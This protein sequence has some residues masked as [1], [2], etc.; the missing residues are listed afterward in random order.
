MTGER[1]AKW[2]ALLYHI[3]GDAGAKPPASW[4]KE[5]DARLAD[6]DLEDFRNCLCA[7]FAPVRSGEPLPLSVAGSHVL[8]GLLWYCALARDAALNEAALCLVDARWK[9]KRNAEKCTTALIQLLESMPPEF[10]R[11]PMARLEQSLAGERLR[12]LN[13]GLS[14]AGDF[15]GKVL[16]QVATVA[17][18]PQTTAE[19][20]RAQKPCFEHRTVGDLLGELGGLMAGL[21]KR[22]RA[23]GA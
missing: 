8:K 19:A 15:I 11:E 5:A 13:A 12:Q 10:S 14:E 16:Q 7:W 18:T 9:P 6:V 17:V 2:R 21:A 1:R 22:N 23:P 4:V 3:R 20:A